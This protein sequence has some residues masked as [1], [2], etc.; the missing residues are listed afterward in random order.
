MVRYRYNQQVQPPA[1]FAYATL[2]DVDERNSIGEVPAQLDIGAYRSVVPAAFIQRLG[3]VQIRQIAV[4]GL[5]A[6]TLLLPTFVVK[7]QLRQLPT[8]TLEV[9][10][11]EGEPHVLLGRDVLNH[12]RVLL[13]G[14]ALAFEIG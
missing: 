1:P 9:Y 3:L 12:Y 14:P 5:G 13:D 11:C 7:I 4:E 6:R 2:F 8:Q 10:G